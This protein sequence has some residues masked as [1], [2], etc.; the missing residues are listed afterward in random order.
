MC[1]KK[2]VT[3]QLPPSYFGKIGYPSRY[4]SRASTAAALSANELTITRYIAFS[5]LNAIV[6]L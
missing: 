3:S 2:A 1:N 5:A 6:A 4:G